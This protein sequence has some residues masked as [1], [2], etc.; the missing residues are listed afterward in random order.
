MGGLICRYAAGRVFQPG[1]NGQAPT[2]A[3]LAPCHF[4]SLATPHLGC[5]ASGPAE[6]SLHFAGALWWLPSQ[7]VLCCL[8]HRVAFAA[9][10]QALYVAG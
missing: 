10:L 2:I 1:S 4:L 7:A 8:L 5:A 3:G 9:G 6:V